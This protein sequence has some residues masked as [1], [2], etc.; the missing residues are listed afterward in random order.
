MVET[1]S[2]KRNYTQNH[3]YQD[4]SFKSRNVE[5]RFEVLLRF[6]QVLSRIVEYITNRNVKIKMRKNQV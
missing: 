4:C 1:H 3:M 2:F 6:L 5:K